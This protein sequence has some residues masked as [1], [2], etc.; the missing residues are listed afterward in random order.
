MTP[1]ESYAA[2]KSAHVALALASGGLFAL[3]GLVRI[4]GS[5]AGNRS[6][7]RWLSYAIDTVLLAAGL[8]LVLI[9]RL[10]PAASPWLAVKLALLVAYI[11][12]GSL[13]LKRARTPSRRALAFAAALACFASMYLIARAHDP[14]APLR[15]LGL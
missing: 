13:A 6:S 11:V 4:A 8:W 2:I 10:D 9:L 12:L 1:A 7:V 5:E 15:W 3:R 14:L